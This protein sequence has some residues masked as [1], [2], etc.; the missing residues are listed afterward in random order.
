MQEERDV[1]FRGSKEDDGLLKEGRRRRNVQLT[2]ELRMAERSEHNHG[3][4]AQKH[5]A[6]NAVEKARTA[7][8]RIRV[9]VMVACCTFEIL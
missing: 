1:E 2:E 6:V 8:L 4:S 5:G 3:R 7:G 9:K